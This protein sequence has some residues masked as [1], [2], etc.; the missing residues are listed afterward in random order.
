V[1]GVEL[2]SGSFHDA[3]AHPTWTVTIEAPAH[4][5]FDGS[6]EFAEAGSNAGAQ[7]TEAALTADGF[8]P[9]V[10]TLHWPHYAW[11]PLAF[12]AARCRRAIPRSRRLAPMRRGCPPMRSPD[13]A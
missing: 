11:L 13:T 6:L 8:T 12:P 4:S 2:L 7:Q 10:T 9:S 1:R 3:D 5:P